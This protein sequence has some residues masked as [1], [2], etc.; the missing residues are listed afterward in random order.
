MTDTVQVFTEAW[1]LMTSRFPDSRIEDGDDVVSCMGNV[2][3]L[4]F[5]LWVQQRPAATVDELLAL[6]TKAAER[7]AK[8]AYPAG[9]V[10]REDWLPSGWEGV[11]AS[12]GLAP[13]MPMTGMET[14]QLLAPRRTAPEL[15]IRRVT[16]AAVARDLATVN[17]LAYGM[18]PE[19]FDCMSNMLL[20]QP[21]S[22][23]FVGYANGRPVSTAAALP[24]AGTV[25][26]ALVATM[27]D[28]QGKGYADA[29]MRH[30]IG[31][32]QRAMGIETTTLHATD[33]GQPV[34][35]AMGYNAG[36]RFILVGPA[37]EGH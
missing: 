29:V 31:E 28:A 27:P 36:A 9:G 15:E 25:Y 18:S 20:W 23:G 17:A 21:D 14:T 19:A 24:V 6:F 35:R 3:L 10:L 8:C 1:K 33:A 4:F 7:S 30:A 11:A 12:C 34:Y 37:T 22:Y 13:M 32:G 26:I 16:D 2:P 5:N